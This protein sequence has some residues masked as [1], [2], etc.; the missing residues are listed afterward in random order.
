MI[1]VCVFI[2]LLTAVAAVIMIKI[3]KR[4][5]DVIKQMSLVLSAFLII[6]LGA[7]LSVFNINYYSSDNL[8]PIPLSAGLSNYADCDG[9]YSFTSENGYIELP[10][11]NA[12][13]KNIYI[14]IKDGSDTSSVGVK[15]ALTDEANK[16]YYAT[17]E[18]TIYT[19]NE[20]SQY[21]NIHSS[22]KTNHIMINF[23]I[24]SGDTLSINGIY[25]N[26]N[27]PFE[28]SVVRVL[29][30]FAILCLIYMFMPS[31]EL[32]KQKLSENKDIKKS[33]VGAAIC[34]Q[35]AIII[36]LGTINPT[37]M[38]IASGSYNSY[39]WDGNGVD[40]VSLNMKNHNQYDELA[41]AFLKGKTYIDNDD[42]PDSLKNLENPYDTT[43]RSYAAAESG[44]TYRWDVAYYNGHYYVYFG[45]I[46]LLLMYLPTRLIFDVPFPSAVGI[47]IFA[48]IFSIGVYKLLI[49]LAEKKFKNVSVGTFLI[50]SVTFI[51][52]CG[53]MFLVKRPDFY[54]VPII[55]GMAF[56]VWGLYNWFYALLNEKHRTL[57]FFIGALFM[58]L[59][60]GCRP[61]MLLMSFL[62]LPLFFKK[63]FIDKEIVKKSGIKDLVA[64]GVPYVVIAAGIMTYNYMR[65]GSPADFGSSYNLTTNDVTNRGFDFGRIGLGL[66]T[67]LFQTPVFTA[68]FPFIQK[69]TIST[70]YIGK[71]IHENC[72]GGLITSL[73]LLWFI[74][75]FGRV[76]TILKEKKLFLFTALTIVIGF[77]VVVADT[78]AGGLLQRY[79]SD[80]GFIFF[81]A[82]A[83]IIFALSERTE[84][85][86]EK[87][88]L[89]TLV[90]F[91]SILSIFYSVALAFSVSDVTIDTQNPTLFAYLSSLVEFWL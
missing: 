32:Y 27:R 64:L 73:P 78:E 80:F 77:A 51:N 20:K 5:N 85:A 55:T 84:T 56:T 76:K 75:A 53:A 1:L 68:K 17:P 24:E 38:G 4:K 87:S 47:M 63:F 71:T 10:E 67:Y 88:T 8:Q 58:A 7:E 29:L 49:L 62:A 43:A 44:D 82:A 86:R 30:V 36:V 60:A 2:A 42:V 83:I 48:L 9:G 81:I 18:R 19:S 31:S 57:R 3:S 33:L 37:F 54:S 65:F 45:I 40:L 50:T 74:A 6:A 46:P 25:M 41:Q 39:K 16:Y 35:C 23:D 91:A 61:Q 28:F 72:F 26:C 15:L 66:F 59:V 89:N 13:V 52:C 12:D 21:I 70:Q 79:Y 14:D 34:V 69:A 90:F 22:G 11:I